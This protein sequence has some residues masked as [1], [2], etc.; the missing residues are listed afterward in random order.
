M[1]T[2]EKDTANSEWIEREMAVLA[3]DEGKP[4]IDYKGF[5]LIELLLVVAILA[6]LAALALPAYDNYRDMAKVSR[7]K[8]EIPTLDQYIAIFLID[9][10]AN[11]DQLS[12]LPQ[13]AFNDPWG[14][15]YRYYNIVTNTPAGST[16]YTDIDGSNLNTDYDLYSV[17]KDN[18]TANDLT[19]QASQDDVVRINDG[20]LL[21]L[22]SK[23]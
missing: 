5:T 9:R 16:R 14:H 22:G 20:I 6:I 1:N 15:P 19:A 10:G 21:E 3:P 4:L 17:G 12:D 13:I 23:R 11:P 18:N 8:A 2:Q 7:C